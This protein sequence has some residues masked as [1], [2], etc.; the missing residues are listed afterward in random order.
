MRTT[1]G[2]S[3]DADRDVAIAFVRRSWFGHLAVYTKQFFPATQRRVQQMVQRAV[4]N[5]KTN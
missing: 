5:A 1:Y 2:H 3:H 4:D